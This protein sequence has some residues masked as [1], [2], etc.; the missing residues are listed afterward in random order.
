MKKHA[1]L[2]EEAG[3]DP[4]NQ[5]T[6]LMQEPYDYINYTL[7]KISKKSSVFFKV[8]EFFDK[9]KIKA[10]LVQ[11]KAFSKEPKEK[12]WTDPKYDP[13]LIS[14]ARHY[15]NV[16]IIPGR[17]N[18]IVF[19]CDS[20][21]TI[22]FFEDLA[23][24][25]DLDL[26]TLVIQTRKGKHYYYYCEFSKELER[27]QF[28]NNQIK[29]DI[30]A[31]SGC[32]VVAPF[33]QL[34]IDESGN[35]LDPKAEEYVLFEYKP[36]NI[37]EKLVE[38]TREQYETIIE[39]LN[40]QFKNRQKIEVKLKRI[41]E[42]KEVLE[43]LAA[44]TGHYAE[45]RHGRYG[46]AWR[47]KCPC[48][49]DD[50]PS[51]DVEIIDGK[52]HFKCWAG[53]DEKEIAKKIGYELEITKENNLESSR[54]A[55]SIK[56]RKLLLENNFTFW[57]SQFEEPYISLSPYQHMKIE[58]KE[59]KDWLQELSCK[60]FEKPLHNQ[61]MEE[62]LAYCRVWARESGLNFWVN[63][64]VGYSEEDN[65]IEVNLLRNDGKVL[66][67]S[68]ES[69][70]L[71]YPRLK[72]VANKNQLP[73]P[74]DYDLFKSLD[75]KQFTE[76]ELLSLFG[77]VFNIQTREELALLLAWMIKT[78]YP[79]GEYPILVVLGEREGVG[80][81]T[82]CKFIVQ[83]LDPCKTPLKRIPR[84]IEDLYSLAKNN[85]I[86]CFDNLSHISEDLSDAF[87]Q[88]ST[89]GSLS[90]RK[91]Y[92]DAENIDLPLKNPLILNSIYS[93]AQKRDLRRRCITLE[94]KKP[95]EYK[96]IEELEENF[97]KTA[98]LIYS[99]LVFCVQEALKKKEI[100]LK[101]LD[102][103]TT[104]RFVANAH[105]VFF[106]SGK[107]FVQTLQANREEVAREILESSLLLPII[108]EKLEPFGIW[109][110]TAK[111]LLD[112]LKK[113]YPNEKNLPNTP[114]KI[115]R[116]LKKLVSD[117]EAVNIK[118]EF[119]KTKKKRLIVFSY[120]QPN[121]DPEDNSIWLGDS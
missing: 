81:S 23:K 79:K 9:L 3:W 24:K 30:L 5:G 46:P 85:F 90:K 66:R 29:L 83:L 59:F 87:C 43:K 71:D 41:T 77:Q 96:T 120:I 34:K 37:P 60:L 113:R 47:T 10:V 33:S 50:H 38:I 52:I 32:Q 108:Q 18:L 72:F 17:S 98:P 82:T 28:H 105:P 114:K 19:D 116:E 88:L 11:L 58:S 36:V 56:V 64:R 103:T 107:E 4:G 100:Q 101:K 89:E 12:G 110:T 51:L 42:L 55:I 117:L 95:T 80:K 27:K 54:I 73:I 111:E 16:G 69:I 115:G 1:H 67:I 7:N 112:E 104:C 109:Q 99:Y 44:L 94:L 70:E 8:R 14:W 57:L 106:I 78:F 75:P 49:D 93:I 65:F 121:Y 22:Q 63:T 45:P 91:L 20:T 118:T 119:I 21:E 92:T 102:I 76:K 48:H 74:F 6:E 15:G 86:L 84:T 25:I 35:V 53:C 97:K 31:G 68:P 39:E 62:V 61:A 13:S 2:Q 40:R 26:N